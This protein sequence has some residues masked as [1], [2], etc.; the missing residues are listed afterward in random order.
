M[1]GSGSVGDWNQ[2]RDQSRWKKG[3]GK[4]E[5]KNGEGKTVEEIIR[6]VKKRQE[7]AKNGKKVKE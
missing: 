2:V 4:C 6:R 5:E 7:I 3:K 1:R